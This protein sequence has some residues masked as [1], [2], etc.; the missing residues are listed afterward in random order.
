MN[1]SLWAEALVVGLA[2][3]LPGSLLVSVP[4]V[5]NCASVAAK[6]GVLGSLGA[7]LHL[8]FE[9]TG[10]NAWYCKQGNACKRKEMNGNNRKDLAGA[11]MWFGVLLLVWC[12]SDDLNR[13]RYELALLFG[14]AMVLDLSSFLSK[15]GKGFLEDDW[16]VLLGSAIFSLLIVSWGLYKK[17]GCNKLET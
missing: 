14:L 8:A 16:R 15:D 3:G 17:C 7:S 11:V 6:A 5:A 13:I 10:L 9:A 4:K 1:S 2:F 12:A